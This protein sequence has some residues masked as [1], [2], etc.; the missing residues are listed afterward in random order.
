MDKLTQWFSDNHYA[1]QKFETS[2]CVQFTIPDDVISLATYYF[3]PSKFIEIIPLTTTGQY[4]RERHEIFLDTED[5]FLFKNGIFLSQPSEDYYLIEF[6]QSC[7]NDVLTKIRTYEIPEQEGSEL[8]S[9]LNGFSSDHGPILSRFEIIATTARFSQVLI[10]Y[11]H[12]LLNNGQQLTYLAGSAHVDEESNFPWAL[13]HH[14][15]AELPLSDFPAIPTIQQVANR[16][17]QDQ[18][19]SEQWQRCLNQTLPRCLVNEPIW[20]E[21]S[22]SS[23]EK[24]S[25]YGIMQDFVF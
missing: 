25:S 21:H 3:D 14:G 17:L 22:S 13:K 4:Y 19:I 20:I 2:N 16:I 8:F 1:C 5:G 23:Q 10:H 11:F 15:Y 9:Q 6:H 24:S 7:Q 18:P 12:L